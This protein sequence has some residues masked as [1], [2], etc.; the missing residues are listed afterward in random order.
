MTFS[1]KIFN[2]CRDRGW[3][4]SGCSDSY[5]KMLMSCE[6]SS[7]STRDIA[8][9]IYANTPD[10]EFS[11]ILKAVD[12]AR[13]ADEHITI[14]SK[15]YAAFHDIFS[16]NIMLSCKELAEM[17]TSSKFNRE[18]IDETY[19]GHAYHEQ[20]EMLAGDLIRA[21]YGITYASDGTDF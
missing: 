18:S 17:V 20:F 19:L 13:Y 21:A 9:M 10:T 16:D 3:F 8:M 4:T 1:N 2:I 12:E 6:N 15:D 14:S 5:Q 7:F 11:E